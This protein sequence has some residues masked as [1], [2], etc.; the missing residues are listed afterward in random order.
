MIVKY[1]S[2]KKVLDN[3]AL[4]LF[5]YSNY[6]AINAKL[7]LRYLFDRKLRVVSLM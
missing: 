5:Y 7:I 2:A 6:V 3:H 1:T 4:I